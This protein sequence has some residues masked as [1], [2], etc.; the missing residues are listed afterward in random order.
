[1]DGERAF[2]AVLAMIL[3]TALFV[4][5]VC[6]V[7]WIIVLT[8][9]IGGWIISVVATIVAVFGFFYWLNL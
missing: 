1:M 3:T 5:L 4:L 9:A 2:H 7:V 8:A 6:V